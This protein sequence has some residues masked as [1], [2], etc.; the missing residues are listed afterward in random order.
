MEGE[1]ASFLV[2]FRDLEGDG[3][4]ENARGERVRTA[5]CFTWLL[6]CASTPDPSADCAK[7]AGLRVNLLD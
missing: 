7:L 5:N 1:A 4:G 3:G 2:P 6:S